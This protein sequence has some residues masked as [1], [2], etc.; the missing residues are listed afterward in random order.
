MCVITISFVCFLSVHANMTLSRPMFPLLVSIHETMLVT[1]HLSQPCM[2][3]KEMS[4]S[5]TKI[6]ALHLDGEIHYSVVVPGL[7]RILASLLAC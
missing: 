5:W 2:V 6:C 4:S 1:M 7:A 3:N